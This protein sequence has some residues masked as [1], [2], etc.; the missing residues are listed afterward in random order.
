MRIA[1]ILYPV[2]VLG[3]GKRIAIWVAGCGKR[4]KGCANPEIWNGDAFPDMD[5]ADLK[6]T[7]DGLYEKVDGQ[8]D[9]ITISGGEPFLQSEE[10]L[11]LVRYL[12]YEKQI[13]DILVFSGYS[14]E[15]LLKDDQSA[16]ALQEIVVLVDGEYIEEQ[17]QG[18]VLRGSTN[19]GIRI[20]KQG[21]K[22]KYHKY[23]EENEGRHLVEN[24]KVSDGV[25]SVG[26][27][28]KDFAK[29]LEDALRSRSIV[30]Q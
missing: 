14:M 8:V 2:T 12:K 29:R 13:E 24:F 19:Q 3:P 11:E 17:N 4:C 27:H 26:I 15:E 28:K 20:L 22:Q 7:L 25:V 30:K 21:F 5:M 1:R 9:G 23:M 10:L 16:A 6:K 18:E